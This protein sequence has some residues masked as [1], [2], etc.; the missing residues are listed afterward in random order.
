MTDNIAFYRQTNKAKS[1]VTIRENITTNVFTYS[2]NLGA[3]S[4]TLGNLNNEFLFLS[5]IK[6]RLRGG[7]F[8][9]V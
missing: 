3:R 6:D 1:R 5:G 9:V 8:F 2:R 7:I 4:P